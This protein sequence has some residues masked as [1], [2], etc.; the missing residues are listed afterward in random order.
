MGYQ[1]RTNRGNEGLDGHTQL[2]IDESPARREIRKRFRALMANFGKRVV[3][4]MELIWVNKLEPH[5]S[6]KLFNAL[7]SALEEERMPTLGRLLQMFR[8]RNDTIQWVP[9]KPLTETEKTR[10]DNSAI[11]S[12]L[13]FHYKYGESENA[14]LGKLILKRCFDKGD[15]ASMIARAKELYPKEVVFRWMQDQERAGN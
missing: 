10:A 14:D 8:G 5:A 2:G 6:P 3:P 1:R 13:W 15:P 7:E 12:I 11:L 4:E 9:P